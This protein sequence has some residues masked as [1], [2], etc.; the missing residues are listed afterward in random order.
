M[1]F[2]VFL[3]VVCLGWPLP[4]CK[5]QKRSAYRYQVQTRALRL[6]SNRGH[7][8]MIKERVAPTLSD[9][10]IDPATT[11]QNSFGC[12]SN[13]LQTAMLVKSWVVLKPTTPVQL[14]TWNW[15]P[16]KQ[17]HHYPG[18][19][20]VTLI[21]WSQHSSLHVCFVPVTSGLDSQHKLPKLLL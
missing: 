18:Y 15:T 20:V 13:P 17:D 4:V 19:Y 8:L 21:K 6:L 7:T 2:Q 11:H 9:M 14:C 3:L 5:V 12:S 16:Q 10:A 1:N